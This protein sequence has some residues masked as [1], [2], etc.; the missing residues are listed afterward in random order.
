[1]RN[2]VKIK[3][4]IVLMCVRMRRSEREREKKDIDQT[5]VYCGKDKEKKREV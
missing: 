2:D 5:R 3:K 1:M 4:Q